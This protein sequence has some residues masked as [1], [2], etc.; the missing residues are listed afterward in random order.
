MWLDEIRHPLQ[1]QC[2]HLTFNVQSERSTWSLALGTEYFITLKSLGTLLLADPHDKWDYYERL[3]ELMFAL[4]KC[5]LPKRSSSAVMVPMTLA[6]RVERLERPLVD[7][8]RKNL[9]RMMRTRR[10]NCF[11]RKLWYIFAKNPGYTFKSR[12]SSAIKKNAHKKKKKRVASHI[13]E[14]E[15]IIF[16]GCVVQAAFLP[17]WYFTASLVNPKII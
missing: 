6:N 3:I 10:R 14:A 4:R 1:W 12:G 13:L 5:R 15:H 2:T 11:G 17:L 7:S 9:K 16:V 8:W